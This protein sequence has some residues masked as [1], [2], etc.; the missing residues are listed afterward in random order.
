MKAEERILALLTAVCLTLGALA[1]C[2]SSEG[3]SDGG[4][5]GTT[6]VF[7]D[8]TFN[9]ENEV[10]PML[11]RKQIIIQCRA[12]TAY[13]QR[14]G[15]TW[16]KTHPYS[17]LCHDMP[18]IETLQANRPAAKVCQKLFKYINRLQS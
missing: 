15:R 3:A 18:K 6:F 8:T 10:S 2:S 11:F 4:T 9:A 12:D 16:G 5:A 7:G 1:G 14:P 13:V 17:S